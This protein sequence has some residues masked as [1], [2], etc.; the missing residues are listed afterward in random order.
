MLKK[1]FSV[2]SA[3]SSPAHLHKKFRRNGNK[4]KEFFYLQKFIW[5]SNN[6]ELLADLNPLKKVLKIVKKV[7]SKNVTEKYSLL[8]VLL[9]FVKLVSLNKFF[10]TF[11]KTFSTDFKSS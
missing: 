1:R 3:F 8:P 5:V 11:L 2:F 4:S 9:M 6:A 7:I 10:G